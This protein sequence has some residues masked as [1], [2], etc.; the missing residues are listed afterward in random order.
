MAV[1]LDGNVRMRGDTGPGVGVRVLAED[2]RLRLVAG[3]ELVGDWTISSIGVSA[4]Q[5]GFNVK[6]EGEEFILRTEDDVA[7]AEEIGVVAAS[8]RLARRLAARH[9]PEERELPPEPPE[10]SAN[11]AAIGYAVAGALVVLGG[12]FLSLTGPTPAPAALGDGS[13]DFDFWV[14]FVVGG[15]LMIGVAYVMSI[16][17][18]FARFIATIALTAMVIVFGFAVSGSSA[19]PSQVTAYGFIAGGIVVG[20][21]V[22]FSGSLERQD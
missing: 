20:V 21:A 5:D 3:K 6:A 9:N 14:A 8:P 19:T 10:L 4:L 12:T 1:E 11:L 16:G 13:G 18:R 17:T 15:A 22:L 7:L 2:G